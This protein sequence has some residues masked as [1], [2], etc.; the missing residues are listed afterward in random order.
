MLY[1]PR[2]PRVGNQEVNRPVEVAGVDLP[3]QSDILNPKRVREGLQVLGRAN[4]IHIG[5]IAWTFQIERYVEGNFVDAVVGHV[6]RLGPGKTPLIVLVQTQN[7]V[8]FVGQHVR[9]EQS[10]EFAYSVLLLLIY[11]LRQEIY[12]L[13]VAWNQYG[14]LLFYLQIR[15]KKGL[16]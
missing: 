4:S 11:F 14:W 10:P 3:L 13:R 9:I 1:H 15:K 8:G 6:Q 12:A 7:L 16:K 5:Q 2:H